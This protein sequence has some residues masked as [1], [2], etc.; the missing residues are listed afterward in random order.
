V[1]DAAEAFR[2]GLVTE[3]TAHDRLLDRAV[4]LATAMTEPPADVVRDVKR[5]YVEGAGAHVLAA[6]KTETTI[7]RAGSMDTAALEE[8]GRAVIARNKAQ[9][10]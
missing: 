10:S 9:I 1:L 3:V 8:R 7:A 6:L 5:M 2:I 4:E